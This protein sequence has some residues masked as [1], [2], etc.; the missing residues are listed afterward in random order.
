MT[1]KT[2]LWACPGR[3]GVRLKAGVTSMTERTLGPPLRVRGFGSDPGG[4]R[5]VLLTYQLDGSIRDM[6]W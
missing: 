4:P 6:L 2:S 1:Y 3:G 5:N